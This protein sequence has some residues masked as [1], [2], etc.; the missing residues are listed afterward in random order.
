MTPTI[1]LAAIEATLVTIAGTTATRLAG[2]YGFSR[3]DR[4][5]LRQ[6]LL[7][8]CIIRLPKFDPRRSSHST[9]FRRVVRHRVSSLLDTQRAACRDYRLCRDSI[10]DPVP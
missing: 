4:D 3:S 8:D 1:G 6:E 10:D 5:D 7:L 9:F 2:L